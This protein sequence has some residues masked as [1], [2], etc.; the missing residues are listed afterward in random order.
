MWTHPTDY[1]YSTGTF[2]GF[3]ISTLY[4]V[5]RK[6]YFQ[7]LSVRWS[8]RCINTHCIEVIA[9]CPLGL[10]SIT[11]SWSVVTGCVYLVP[12]ILL[13]LFQLDQTA[14]GRIKQV[15]IFFQS[16]SVI[17]EQELWFADCEDKKTFQLVKIMQTQKQYYLR[18]IIS[19]YLRLTVFCGG[20]DTDGND[21]LYIWQNH[22][23]ML[24]DP[25]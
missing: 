6:R 8:P 7:L 12:C 22:S 5:Y 4:S 25:Q 3:L 13:R 9:V 14:T 1:N 16:I 11:L 10:E 18:E 21:I 23:L 2:S 24:N 20:N 15:T 19:N 17:R